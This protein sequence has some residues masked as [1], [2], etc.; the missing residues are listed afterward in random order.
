MKVFAIA[1]LHLSLGGDKPMDRFGDH[2]LRHWEKVEA[3]WRELV[4]EDDLVLLPGDHS[5][6]MRLEEADEDLGFISA[7]PGTKVLTRGNHD[8]WWQS[9]GKMRRRH[10]GLHFLQNDAL[11]VGNVGICGTRGWDLPGRDGRFEDAH[12]E[13]IFSR[14]VQRLQLSAQALAPDARLRVAMIHYPP[15]ARRNLD[16]GFTRVLEQA[17]VHY[18]VYGHLHL[19]HNHDPFEGQHRGVDYRLVACDYLGFKPLLLTET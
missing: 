11:L 7:L 2:W 15:L 9:L 1:D 10:P 18:C 3:S 13:K 19:G 12:D 16:T 17:G 5:W 14:E 4:T 6:A 8:Y